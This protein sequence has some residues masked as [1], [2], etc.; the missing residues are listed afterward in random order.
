[1]AFGLF[2]GRKE[3]ADII[4]TNCTIHTMDEAMPLADAVACRD[5]IIMRVGSDEDM[6][7]IVGDE[8]EVFDLEE[9][10]VFPGFIEADA[11]PVL[12]AIDE[13]VC[14][15][16]DEDESIEEIL[17]GL[18]DH[19]SEYFTDVTI[20]LEDADDADD[21]VSEEEFDG[22]FDEEFDGFDEE[23]L[24]YLGRT[25]MD[26]IEIDAQ[27]ILSTE[28]ELLPGQFVKAKITGVCDAD[29]VGEVLL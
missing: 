17:S 21:A 11:T 4:Y 3:I 6:Q 25:Y 27:V 2:S 14:Y 13:D 16:I 9:M 8:T 19:I 28:D 26:C 12:D 23:N 5:G 7:D 10:H 18:S 1:M 29:L 20:D 15:V 24:L 22:G